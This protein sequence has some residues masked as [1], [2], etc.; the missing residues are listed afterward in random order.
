MKKRIAL[1]LTMVLALVCVFAVS[2]FADSVHANVDKSQTVTL[3][4]GTVCNL[5]DS[6][7]NALIWYVDSSSSTGYSSIRA[8]SEDITYTCN[9]SESVG[10]SVVGWATLYEV[11]SMA[12]KVNGTTIS[13]TNVVVFNI[14]DDDVVTTAANHNS[15][16]GQ[17]VNCIKNVFNKATKLEYAYLRYDTIAIQGSAFYGCDNLKYVNFTDLTELRQIGGGS[18]FWGCIKLFENQTL[19]LSKC[20]K[21]RRISTGSFGGASNIAP[22]MTFNKVILPKNLVDCGNYPFQFSKNLT[23]VEF[24]EGSRLTYLCGNM[25]KSC[26]ALTTFINMPS[27]TSIGES[28]F[29]GCTSLASFEIPAGVTSIGGSAF[30]GCTS[31]TTIEIP[32]SVTSIGGSA[33]ANSGLQTITFA[34]GCQ[35]TSLPAAMLER[36][37]SLTRLEIPEGIVS[38]G[39]CLANGC[40]KLSYLSLPSTLENMT[41]NSSDNSHFEGASLATLIGLENTKIEKIPNDAF[42]GAIDTPMDLKLPSTLKSMGQYSFADCT[43]T[44]IRLS[45]GLESLGSET[46]VNCPGLKEVY[47]P[48]TI[49]AFGT[50]TFNNKLTGNIKFFVVS[51]DETYLESVK[52][53]FSCADVVTLETYEANESAY[54]SGRHVISGYN[55]CDAFYD[56]HQIDEN[57]ATGKWLG[58]KYIS[59]YKVSCECGR[60]CGK[61]AVLE[62][63]EPLFKSNGFASNAS[64]MMQ[65]FAVNK[66]L[67]E[68]YKPYLGEIKFGLVA[69]YCGTGT[70]FDTTS[71]VLVNADGTGVNNKIAIVDF[72]ER[73]YDIFEMRIS[74]IDD[75]TKDMEFYI[76]AYV[77]ENGAVSYIHNNTTADKAEATTYTAVAAL[78]KTKYDYLP[79]TA[80]EEE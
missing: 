17:P 16:L 3:N 57:E 72:T 2:V 60:N 80:K 15:R 5:F 37:T 55:L 29:N 62:T 21:L 61:E 64:A 42:K 7:G 9:Y 30:Y 66:S 20:Q 74:G 40:T 8:D 10:D 51:T 27:I 14:M 4:D 65:S 24:E 13:N 33:F 32:A 70:D 22:S 46:F 43:L 36:C 35:L 44:T 18:E 54:E 63:L 23:T 56:D 48:G 38:I 11:S 47:V 1:I 71:G 25:F 49:T 39:N 19:D 78:D 69:A 68:A 26:P 53:N 79:A 34:Q 58:D 12:I 41:V 67:I 52:S 73:E 6:E 50:S 28:T 59:Q 76:C 31:L 77:I 45:V 75:S